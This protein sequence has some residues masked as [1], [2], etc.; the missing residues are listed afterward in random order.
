MDL[1][2]SQLLQLIIYCS[3]LSLYITILIILP[4]LHAGNNCSLHTHIQSNHCYLSLCHASC[5]SG[6]V[7]RVSYQLGQESTHNLLACT[8]LNLKLQCDTLYRSCNENY[9]DDSSSSTFDRIPEHHSRKFE[10]CAH[11]VCQLLEGGRSP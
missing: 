9:V 1:L 11:M 7:T 8:Q 3:S 5:T 2:H 6:C 4:R 10:M